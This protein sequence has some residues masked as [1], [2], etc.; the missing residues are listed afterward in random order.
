MASS[1]VILIGPLYIKLAF[2]EVAAEDDRPPSWP[3]AE[4]VIHTEEARMTAETTRHLPI[5]FE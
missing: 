4:E 2:A 5:L 1:N 3:E